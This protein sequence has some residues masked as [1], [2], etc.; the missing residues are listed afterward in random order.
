VKKITLL[1]LV[2]V[3]ALGG[4]GIGF[5][6]W[7]Q[8]LIVDGYIETG[9]FEVGIRDVGVLDQGPDPNM[10]PGQ[11]P[12]GKDVAYHESINGEP[13]CEHPEWGI[14]YHNIYETILNVYPYYMSGT[15][16]EF[17]NCGTI[18][19]KIEDASMVVIDG[20][21]ALLDYL[22]ITDWWLD[23]DDVI[24]LNGTGIDDLMRALEYYQ[25]EPCHKLS[26]NVEFYFEEEDA[27]GNILPQGD[28]VVFQWAITWSQWNEVGP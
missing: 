21:P 19:A 14:F 24:F 2:L 7:S 9:T 16:L 17:G 22:V 26:L 28:F 10:E 12:E 8:T 13:K 23:L 4:M 11:N 20:N 25:L 15:T 18:P 3:L 5:A 27:A 6:K 1:L